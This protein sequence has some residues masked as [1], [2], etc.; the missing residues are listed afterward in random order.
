MPRGVGNAFQTLED[1]TAYSYLVNDHWSLAAKDSYTFLNLADETV[2]IDWPIPLA[3]AE[4]SA[5][6]EAHP[7]L[8]DVT[9][10]APRP[11]LILGAERAAGPGA[12]GRAARRRR[13]RPG[14][15]RPGRPGSR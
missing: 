1:E 9:P 7:R 5:A 3:Q 11:T 8:A 6:D 4:L 14:P 12:G 10:M 15:A 2:A 13:R